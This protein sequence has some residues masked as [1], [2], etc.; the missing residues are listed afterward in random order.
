MFVLPHSAARGVFHFYH[1]MWSESQASIWATHAERA[2]P[3]LPGQ[4]TVTALL[5]GFRALDFLSNAIP[6]VS[7]AGHLA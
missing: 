4:Q 7:Q 1:R 3:A 2:G 5:V 6:C